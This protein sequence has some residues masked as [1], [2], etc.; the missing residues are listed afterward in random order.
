M[1]TRNRTTGLG[2]DETCVFEAKLYYSAW[3]EAENAEDLSNEKRR[4]IAKEFIAEH[5]DDPDSKF[6]PAPGLWRPPRNHPLRA[7]IWTQRGDIEEKFWQLMDER[8][9]IED[10]D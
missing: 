9:P 5:K 1:A 8:F 3:C 7:D 10:K 4:R 2:A 6:N